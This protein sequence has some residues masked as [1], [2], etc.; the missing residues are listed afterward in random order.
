MLA[1]FVCVA[2]L[3][4]T[5]VLTVALSALAA[6]P[7]K[8]RVAAQATI[9]TVPVVAFPMQ[10]ADVPRLRVTFPMRVAASQPGAAIR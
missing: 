5:A 9:A 4:A 10:A 6:E 7:L 8:P 1:V 3:H 2:V